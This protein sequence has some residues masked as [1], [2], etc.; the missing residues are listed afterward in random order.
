MK[1]DSMKQGSL[2]SLQPPLKGYKLLSREAYSMAK[3][4]IFLVA[5]S[6]EGG[7][8]AKALSH[9][10]YTEGETLAELKAAIRDAVKCN[11]EEPDIPQ[12]IRHA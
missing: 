4:I 1:K 2:M 8:E 3:K 6:A 5:E 7:Y 9:S 12:M 10:I 11:F